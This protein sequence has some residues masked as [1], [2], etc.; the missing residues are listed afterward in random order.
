M[1]HARYLRSNT[2]DGKYL[3][4]ISWCPAN[5]PGMYSTHVFNH[6]QSAQ[7]CRYTVVGTAMHNFDAFGSSFDVM[8]VNHALYPHTFT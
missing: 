2:L 6:Q 4:V 8:S 5:T 7:V 1:F 3:F